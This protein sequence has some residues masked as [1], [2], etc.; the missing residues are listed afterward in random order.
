[1]RNCDNCDCGCGRNRESGRCRRAVERAVDECGSER[2]V[3]RALNDR[4]RDCDC[5]EERAER[6]EA[7]AERAERRA[8]R[9]ERIADQNNSCDVPG[10]IPPHWQEYS[11]VSRS[12]SHD[13]CGCDA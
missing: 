4:D 12:S 3:A 10:I 13:D 11:G 7:R 8:D 1:M 2:A 5:A 6:A 9:A